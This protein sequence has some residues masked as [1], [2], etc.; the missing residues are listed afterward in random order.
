LAA[1]DDMDESTFEVG[2]WPVDLDSP[3]GPPSGERNKLVAVAVPGD[4][5]DRVAEGL[6]RAG[7]H[8]RV[9]DVAPHAMARAIRLCDPFCDEPTIGLKIGADSALFVLI[10]QGRPGFCRV[11]RGCGFHSLAEPLIAKLGMSFKE[12]EQILLHH[13]IPTDGGM[14]SPSNDSFFRLFS[15]PLQKLVDE[16]KRTFTFIR[17]GRPGESA[18]RIWLFG[19]GAAVRNLPSFLASQC[20]IA[21]VGWSP[22]F[23][24]AGD[25]EDVRYGIAAGLSALPWEV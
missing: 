9:L 18:T 21:A 25:V 15:V 23:P 19:D 13:G 5:S 22:A 6:L 1:D 17:Q 12:A 14:G 3:A 8:P 20:G 4:V 11:L 16:V 7:Y 2:A 24:E 10:R